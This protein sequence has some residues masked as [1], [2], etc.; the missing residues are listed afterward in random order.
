MCVHLN[1]Y[2]CRWIKIQMCNQN[3]KS[4]QY[5]GISVTLS[6]KILWCKKMTEDFVQ[7]WQNW[8]FSQKW[9]IFI[10][11][12][13]SDGISVTLGKSDKFSVAFGKKIPSLLFY[14]L[15]VVLYQY[16]VLHLLSVKNL[17]LDIQEFNWNNHLSILILTNVFQ[18]FLL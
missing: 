1:C 9:L 2:Y 15:E 12:S 18:T 13:E 6:V 11:W 7:K 16:I 5:I 8:I 17:Y 4:I 3:Y 14:F 10:Q